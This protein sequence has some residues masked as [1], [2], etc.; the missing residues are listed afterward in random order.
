MVP[1]I[2]GWYLLLSYTLCYGGPTWILLP[3]F[4]SQTLHSVSFCQKDEKDDII[5]GTTNSSVKYE[6]VFCVFNRVSPTQIFVNLFSLYNYCYTKNSAT[7]KHAKLVSTM[8]PEHRRIITYFYFT[9]NKKW[10]GR[11]L[12]HLAPL[13]LTQNRQFIVVHDL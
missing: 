5:M 7:T 8:I 3:C 6:L 9:T 10:G 2:K 11:A 13:L 12:A 1:F 4:V